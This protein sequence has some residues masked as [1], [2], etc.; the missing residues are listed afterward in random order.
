MSYFVQRGI[1]SAN[2]LLFAESEYDNNL[3]YESES[4]RSTVIVCEGVS[5]EMVDVNSFKSVSVSSILTEADSGEASVEIHVQKFHLEEKGGHVEPEAGKNEE[6]VEDFST[7]AEASFWH[8]EDLSADRDPIAALIE[9]L[10]APKVETKPVVDSDSSDILQ[11]ADQD[12]DDHSMLANV[13]SYSYIVEDDSQDEDDDSI[14]AVYE[15]S[16]VVEEEVESETAVEKLEQAEDFK[17]EEGKDTMDLAAENAEEIIEITTAD[18]AVTQDAE[19]E[20]DDQEKREEM[21]TFLGELS[22]LDTYWRRSIEL[23]ELD[24]SVNGG[25]QN[26]DFEP[27]QAII[28]VAA[29]IPI[30]L[31]APIQ[32]ASIEQDTS[33]VLPARIQTQTLH[34]TSLRVILTKVTGLKKLSPPS[35]P[36]FKIDISIEALAAFSFFGLLKEV[37]VGSVRVKVFGPERPVALK[38]IEGADE[39]ADI[40]ETSPKDESAL[41]VVLATPRLAFAEVVAPVLIHTEEL[42]LVAKKIAVPPVTSSLDLFGPPVVVRLPPLP[43]KIKAKA[44]GVPKLKSMIPSLR[45]VDLDSKVGDIAKETQSVDEDKSK[46]ASI[47]ELQAKA[48]A[49]VQVVAAGSVCELFEDTPK[50]ALALDTRVG[51]VVKDVKTIHLTDDLL[52]P[53]PNEPASSVSGDGASGPKQEQSFKFFGTFLGRTKSRSLVNQDGGK[54]KTISAKCRVYQEVFGVYSTRLKSTHDVLI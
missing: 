21:L 45:K 44:N 13:G 52:D 26:V 24:R 33:V 36:L 4:E 40:V 37:D 54:E 18:I 49:H 6:A 31:S 17:V 29:A 12:E 23:S 32:I 50:E 41:Q 25:S 28:Q 27:A 9:T 20:Q 8:E 19:G 7:T 46:F 51:C 38:K 30:T 22:A 39:A 34:P 53:I 42:P 15:P 35:I 14:I 11:D 5:F 10:F 1:I 48:P 43:I 2:I 16:Y 47:R 3:T